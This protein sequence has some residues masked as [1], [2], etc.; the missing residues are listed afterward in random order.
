MTSVT[1]RDSNQILFNE[2]HQVF[3]LSCTS[4]QSLLC[5]DCLAV[6]CLGFTVI[7]E[8]TVDRCFVGH[9]GSQAI[10]AANGD[11][12][13]CTYSTDEVQSLVS[14]MHR[15]QSMYLLISGLTT[16][17]AV[18]IAGIRNQ[19]ISCRPILY[20]SCQHSSMLFSSRNI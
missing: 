1:G 18:N 10:L 7:S 2:D 9:L 15:F 3:I 13:M 12:H 19:W 6:C 11:L 5:I 4:G 14:S 20:I 8:R 16:M 17:N